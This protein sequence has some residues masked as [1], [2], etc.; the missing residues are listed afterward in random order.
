[1]VPLGEAALHIARLRPAV[2]KQQACG[3]RGEDPATAHDEH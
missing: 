1:V 3:V 2:V